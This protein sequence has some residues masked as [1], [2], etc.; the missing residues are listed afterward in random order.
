MFCEYFCT[1]FSDQLSDDKI[2][3]EVRTEESDIVGKNNIYRREDIKDGRFSP[4]FFAC[5]YEMTSCL[6]LSTFWE[7]IARKEPSTIGAHPFYRRLFHYRECGSL[8]YARLFK[9]RCA[10]VYARVTKNHY[11]IKLAS[12]T[13]AQ[14]MHINDQLLDYSPIERAVSFLRPNEGEPT[15]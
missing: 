3:S 8:R 9:P 7:F 13:A 11:L 5:P 1:R 2:K 12:L 6:V 15:V 4:L 14:L 10:H